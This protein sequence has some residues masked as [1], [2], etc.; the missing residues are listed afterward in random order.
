MAQLTTPQS[1]A[2]IMSFYN[3]PEKGPKLN[4]KIVLI[5]IAVFAIVI[6]LFDHF[7]VL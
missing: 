1:Q 6:L 7:A 5:V 3:A 4:A 2:G